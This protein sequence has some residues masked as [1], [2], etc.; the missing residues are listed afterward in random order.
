MR[1]LPVRK[2]LA[3]VLPALAVF[4]VYAAIAR[5]TGQQ[6]NHYYLAAGPL[7]GVVG[8]LAY[9]RRPALPIVLGLCFGIVGLMFSLQETRSPLF[10]DVVWTGLV[11]AFL[12]WVAGVCAM[13]T[14]PAD[15]RFNGA[16]TM[17]VVG[18]IAGIAFQFLY[19]PAHFLFDLGG[20]N[21]WGDRPWEHLVLWLI[22]A[23]GAAWTLGTNLQV[24][25]NRSD[26]ESKSESAQWW[27]VASLACVLVAIIIGAAYL[28]RSKLPLG[29]F[30]S[31]SPIAAA[32]DWFWGWG[33]LAVTIAIIGV[34]KRTGRKWE[35]TALAASVALV[36]V[37]FRIN[38]D[39]WKTRFNSSYA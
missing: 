26:T 3:F 29:L 16:M 35:I 33:V 23:G 1:R 36:V 21:W 27:P 39:P 11:S 31:L 17:A 38:A 4:A 25:E 14:L 22:V 20:R 28:V 10:S 19:G 2:V 37:S 5:A 34:G 13:L 18:L 24:K 6:R 15:L 32:A 30:N 7:C 9:A 12:F 8:G